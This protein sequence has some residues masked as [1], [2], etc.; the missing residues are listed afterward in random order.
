[1]PLFILKSNYLWVFKKNKI[2]GNYEFAFSFFTYHMS[3]LKKWNARQSY[4]MPISNTFSFKVCF[5]HPSGRWEM[6]CTCKQTEMIHGTMIAFHQLH[7]LY[8]A[9]GLGEIHL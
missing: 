4:R 1:M 9:M 5:V 6:K 8:T 2:Y 3:Q 7:Q